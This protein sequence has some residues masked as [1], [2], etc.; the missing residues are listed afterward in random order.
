MAQNRIRSLFELI[1]AQVLVDGIPVD[2]PWVSSNLAFVREMEAHLTTDANETREGRIDIN[3]AHYEALAGLP[4]V[5]TA[6]VN[7]ILNGAGT[8]E[9]VAD[10]LAKGTVDIMT[11][12]EIEPFLTTASR[13]YRFT[14]IGV[15]QSG[16]PIVRMEAVIDVAGPKPV[17]LSVE[18]LTPLGPGYLRE[19]L[20]P[21]TD[22]G[23]W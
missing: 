23:N 8:W 20:V 16:G 9:S 7:E 18:N 10:L 4:N 6:L 13:T 21:T 1:D 14:S 15:W 11:L 17:V 5:S 2:S 12:R 22:S 3:Y 19:D